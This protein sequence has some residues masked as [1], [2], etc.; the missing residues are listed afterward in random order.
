LASPAAEVQRSA[1]APRNLSAP[2]SAT[3]IA[4]RWYLRIPQASG[5]TT[6]IDR[7]TPV[8]ADGAARRPGPPRLPGLRL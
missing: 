3:H 5:S 1:R 7:I 2:V 8:L 6:I 4:A